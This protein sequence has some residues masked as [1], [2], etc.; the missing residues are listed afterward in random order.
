MPTIPVI[1]KKKSITK[2][3]VDKLYYNL[4]QAFDLI[5]EKAKGESWEQVK[6]CY[7][8]CNFIDVLSGLI[9]YNFFDLFNYNGLIDQINEKQKDNL[10]RD[11][12][13]FQSFAH[14]IATKDK[15]IVI[16]GKSISASSAKLTNATKKSF[17][18]KYNPDS[19]TKYKATKIRKADE[20]ILPS[21][22]DN[23]PDKIIYTFPT[24]FLI[25][26]EQFDYV[27]KTGRRWLDRKPDVKY[28]GMLIS[29]FHTNFYSVS[30]ETM[31]MVESKSNLMSYFE[32]SAQFKQKFNAEEWEIDNWLY[33]SNS[34]E[35]IILKNNDV[36]DD[37]YCE[38]YAK[39]NDN[40]DYT[41]TFYYKEQVN[42]FSSKEEFFEYETLLKKWKTN[43]STNEEKILKLISH[44]LSFIDAQRL[45]TLEKFG[46][47]IPP[48]QKH[49]QL[50]FYRDE[51]NLIEKINFIRGA[52][53]SKTYVMAM[54]EQYF[55]SFLVVDEQIESQDKK[56]KNNSNNRKQEN[57]FIFYLEAE[58]KNSPDKKPFP[59]L[60]KTGD[61]Y[62]KIADTKYQ[63]TKLRRFNYCWKEATKN[64]PEN[65]CWM[66]AGRPKNNLKNHNT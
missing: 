2:K 29:R 66:K 7:T 18:Q 24:N 65:S 10:L 23:E 33:S 51:A 14:K 53:F 58:I 56:A 39:T 32:L 31:A 21:I 26:K 34:K 45:T 28:N 35:L 61:S 63:I 22:L 43:F 62:Q 15:D 11:E 5:G 19:N 54:E 13:N 16:A 20:V 9:K 41:K 27:I 1:G 47:I 36:F 49:S 64:L 6:N 37:G 3:E 8:S 60:S 50:K 59:K 48:T 12:V 55:P 46:E 57:D 38:L 25:P 40:P 44:H 4:N 42:S 30:Q 17:Y 52:M